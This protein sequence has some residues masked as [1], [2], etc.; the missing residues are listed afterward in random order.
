MLHTLNNTIRTL[1]IH[2]SMPP[3]YWAEALATAVVLLNRRPSTS[4]NNDI[5]YHRLYHKMPDYS[6]LRVFGCLCYPNLSATTSHKLAPRSSACVFIGYPSSQKG[7]RCLDLST[8]RVIISRHVVFDEA[9]FPFA[10][11]KPPP[12]SLDFLVQGRPPVPAPSSDVERT[13]SSIDQSDLADLDPAIIWHGPV[14]HVS[15]A[16]TG[17]SLAP[18]EPAQASAPAGSPAD[19]QPAAAAVQRPPAGAHRPLRIYVRQLRPLE[20]VQGPVRPTP[21]LHRAAPA[22][23]PIPR[24]QPS[25]GPARVSV[26]RAPASSRPV[27]RAQMGSLPPPPDRL[28]LSATH[29]SPL[30]A[31]YRSALADPNWRA[32]MVDEYRALIDNGTWRLV[33]RPPRANVVSGKW[34]FKHKYHSDGSLASHKARWVVR[35]FSQQHGLDYDE[36]FSPVVKPATIRVILSLAVS[37]SWPIHQLDVKNAFLHGHLEET[38]YCQ[39]PPG[40]VDPTA[41]DHVCLLQVLIRT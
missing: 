38:V 9:N 41:P 13:R 28:T 12:E 7:Y 39:Q 36:T 23:S 34:I 1:L 30:P 32:A 40:F 29:A 5:P 14:R 16:P 33:P 6:I 11:T 15:R 24:A 21:L 19:H 3:T 37:R 10:V 2:A 26:P 20:H 35:G 31:N 17:P 4:I 25:L 8:R 22:P 27:T 18:T